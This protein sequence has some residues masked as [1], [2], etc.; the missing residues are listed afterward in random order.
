MPNT[1]TKSLVSVIIPTYNRAYCIEHTINSVLAQTHSRVEAVVVDDG[2]TDATGE[3][4]ASKFGHDPRVRYHLRENGG[5]SAARNTGISIAKGEFIAFLDSDDLWEPWKL[6]LQL[7]AFEKRPEIGMVWTDMTAIDSE[8]RVISTAYLRK[9]YSAHKWFPTGELFS[10]S[11]T[12]DEFASHLPTGAPGAKFHTGEIFS[13]IATGNLAHTSTVLVRRERLEKA[14]PFRVEY[15]AAGED[16]ELFV[17]ICKEGPVGFL[18]LSTIIYQVG[19][20]DQITS[21]YHVLVPRTFLTIFNETL[22]KH[23]DRL[24]LSPQLINTVLAEAHCWLGASLVNAGQPVEGRKHLVEGLRRQFDA[25]SFRVLLLSLCPSGVRH[26]LRR[27]ARYMREAF[28]Y[29]RLVLPLLISVLVPDVDS[30][31]LLEGIYL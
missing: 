14:G 27:G 16:Y 21:K 26:M 31:A 19:R 29:R 4:I 20:P 18:D 23:R 11:C 9:M 6:E 3:L 15:T 2:S 24:T 25:Y 17:R 22:E 8:G 1:E 13:A 5:V 28:R 10:W 30:F 7:S 12:V